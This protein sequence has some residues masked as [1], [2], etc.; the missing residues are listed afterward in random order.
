MSTA[1]PNALWNR[2]TVAE[3]G[4]VQILN[5]IY[6]PNRANMAMNAVNPFRKAKRTAGMPGRFPT[7]TPGRQSTMSLIRG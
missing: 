5:S 4:A 2:T 7:D 1:K 6:P 3:I